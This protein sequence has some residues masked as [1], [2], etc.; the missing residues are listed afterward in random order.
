MQDV[1]LKPRLAVIAAGRRAR[2]QPA[3]AAR[4]FVPG[5][6]PMR[7]SGTSVSPGPG[8]RAVF[9]CLSPG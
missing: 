1:E 7:W 4:F 9:R 8:R 2:R 3:G 5:D 6:R